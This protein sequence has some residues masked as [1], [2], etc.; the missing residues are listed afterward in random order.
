MC[1]CVQ[2]I[3]GLVV[4]PDQHGD[5]EG[6]QFATAGEKGNVPRM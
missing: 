6:P 5:Q 3:E 1:V 2:A 4:V